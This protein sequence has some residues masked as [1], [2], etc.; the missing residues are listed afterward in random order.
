MTVTPSAL[1]VGK[2]PIYPVEM[3]VNAAESSWGYYALSGGYRVFLFE[4]TRFSN[5]FPAFYPLWENYAHSSRDDFID[6]RESLRQTTMT[7]TV[8]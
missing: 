1:F 2:S 3:I 8:S 5:R 4:Q 7:T 6:R